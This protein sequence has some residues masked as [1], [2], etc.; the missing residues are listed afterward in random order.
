MVSG[1]RSR[2]RTRR[3][4]CCRRGGSTSALRRDRARRDTRFPASR[5]DEAGHGTRLPVARDVGKGAR[6]PSQPPV[7]RSVIWVAHEATGSV[8]PLA[9][10]RLD[11]DLLALC[12]LGLRNADGQDALV[13]AGLDLRS[14]DLL[15]E[16]DAILEAPGASCP[17][18]EGAL[19]L[20][21][22]D[23][24]GDREVVARDLD[25]H[26]LAL[27]PGKLRLEDVGIVLLLDVHQRRPAGSLGDQRRLQAEPAKRLVEHPAHPLGHL[28]E[29]A[30][31][32]PPLRLGCGTTLRK[33][34][35]HQLPPRFSVVPVRA[36]PG[37]TNPLAVV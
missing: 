36:A 8:S 3:T 31:R 37:G 12:A 11:L 35:R 2:R 25:V 18:A 20:L 5:P 13:E 30:Q 28:L 22:L 26:V 1:R 15:R 16:S 7:A 14:V 29:L 33:S 19:A 9:S 34:L 4:G 32:L 27:D 21:L 10:L 23:L 6:R 24:A 17:P